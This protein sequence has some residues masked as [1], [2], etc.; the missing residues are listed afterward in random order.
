MCFWEISGFGSIFLT[1]LKIMRLQSNIF[2]HLNLCH[3]FEI[4]FIW[5]KL[6]SFMQF[7][8]SRV[9]KW[10][11]P[12]AALCQLL[13]CQRTLT[14]HDNGLV[15]RNI[16]NILDEKPTKW[17]YPFTTSPLF[18]SWEQQAC[19]IWISFVVRWIA[20]ILN[21]P[22]H[23][24]WHPSCLVSIQQLAQCEPCFCSLRAY[25]QTVYEN[26]DLSG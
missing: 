20:L 9:L 24:E 12:R 14:R 16:V 11:S 7:W 19:V 13:A 23:F 6:E 21:F 26:T 18:I 5:W 2:Q 1:F 22:T 4:M 15:V 25:Y 17:P 8:D 10:V 3:K